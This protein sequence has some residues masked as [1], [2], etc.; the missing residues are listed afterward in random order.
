MQS[1]VST[2]DGRTGPMRVAAKGSGMDTGGRR[3]RGVTKSFHVSV[4]VSGV[5]MG[6]ENGRPVAVMYADHGQLIYADM[7]RKPSL[8][9]FKSMSRPMRSGAGKKREAHCFT[10]L[11]LVANEGGA[12]NLRGLGPWALPAQQVG[13]DAGGGVCGGGL[14]GSMEGGGVSDGEEGGA[15][16]G[17][18]ITTAPTPPPQKPSRNPSPFCKSIGGC[19]RG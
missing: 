16:G 12:A 1:M 4:N 19:E 9:A 14:W 10:L 6:L 18:S 3:S 17:V 5:R 7:C 15:G 8:G 13:P 2:S 11:L